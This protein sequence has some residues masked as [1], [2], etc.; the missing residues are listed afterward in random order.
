MAASTRAPMV[1]VPPI[2]RL[3]RI[4]GFGSIYGKTIRDS[5]LTFIIAAGL[6]GGLALVMGAAISSVFPTP[7]SRL[8]VDKLIGGMPPQMVDFFGKPEKLGTLGGYLTW[9]YGLVFV[10]A[11]SVWSILALSSTLAGE[12]SRGSPRYRRVGAARQAPHRARETCCPRNDARPRDGADGRP[13]DGQ[14]ERL[15]RSGPG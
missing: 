9:K 11:T 1:A 8:E 13:A 3:S 12:A 10:L 4:Y 2:P 15:R 14:L 5:R 7:E 6:L